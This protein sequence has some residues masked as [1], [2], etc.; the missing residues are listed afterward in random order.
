ENSAGPGTAP[1][2]APGSRS[3]LAHGARSWPVPRGDQVA[4]GRWVPRRWPLRSPAR[5]AFHPNPKPRFRACQ[6]CPGRRIV[7]PVHQSLVIADY[8]ARTN[9]GPLATDYGRTMRFA[10]LGTHPD[11][12]AM[13]RALVASG[14]HELLAYTGTP[15]TGNLGH[16]WGNTAKL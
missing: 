14:R 1:D 6:I 2:A 10:L 11:G 9:P 15:A 8:P 16:G 13:V 3:A 4:A 7:S 12:F 5:T